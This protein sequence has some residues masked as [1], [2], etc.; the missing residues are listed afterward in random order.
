MFIRGFRIVRPLG[1]LPR[2]LRAAAGPNPSLDEDE[3]FDW[4]FA[5]IDSD[6]STLL[7]NDERPRE[8]M[9]PPT[10]TKV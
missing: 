10:S 9:P 5:E 7:D 8:L 6:D 4:A 2:Q 3:D 1:I